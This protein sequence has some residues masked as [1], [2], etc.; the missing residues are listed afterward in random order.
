MTQ[1]YQK[2]IHLS[3]KYMC[4]LLKNPEFRIMSKTEKKL[5]EFHAMQ[6]YL[7]ILFLSKFFAL[8]NTIILLNTGR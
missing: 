8:V 6:F 5:D 2:L 3:N 7:H 4:N 1:Y